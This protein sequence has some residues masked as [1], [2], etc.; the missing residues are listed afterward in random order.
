[1]EQQQRNTRKLL[2]VLPV[3]VL[4]FLALGF[5]ALGGGKGDPSAQGLNA[6]QGINTRL[7]DAQFKKND[8]QDKLSLYN[9]AGKNA[10]DERDSLP[11]SVTG[12]GF[13]SGNVPD[14]NEQRINEK[15]AQISREVSQPVPATTGPAKPAVLKPEMSGDVDRL[16]KLMHTMQEKKGDDPE[17]AQ[18]TG[19]LDKILMIQNPD[20]VPQSTVRPP[21]AAPDS[22]FKAIPAII[23]D[24]QK[25]VQGATIK[26]RLQ[27]SLIINGQVIPKGHDIFGICRITNQRLLLDIKNIRLGTS[28]IPVD[29][30]V[31]SLD[32][33]PG[34]Y[35][36]EAELADAAGSG[37]DDAV[38]SI[39]MS[40]MD[41]TIATQVAG[42][43]LDAAKSLF[44]KKIKRI[45]VKLEAGRAVLL[46][47]N[48]SKTR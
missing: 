12:Q 29:L 37:A 23:V 19:M 33:M 39:G 15:L 30:S 25:A 31:Y 13:G 3:L 44:S 1:M 18:L 38:R 6:K 5:Y 48:K 8:P 46:R 45:K 7:P 36:P 43:G 41:Q 2:L 24:N 21:A 26:L 28:I 4:P 27:D 40:G 34:L 22:L 11:A 16:E 9:L 20:L 32:G 47:N 35:A 17:M 42:A 10:G 14:P